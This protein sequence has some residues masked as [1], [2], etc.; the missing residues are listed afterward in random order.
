MDAAAAERA[1]EFWLG[2]WLQ[3]VLTGDYPKVMRE[4]L[5]E[6]LPRFSAE[7]AK[8]LAGSI[9]VLTLNHY[10]THLV[11]E[12]PPGEAGDTSN[13]WMADQRID[14]KWGDDW[15]QSASVLMAS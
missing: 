14:F 9:D 4:T 15:T 8:L 5:G 7:E 12:P 6:R 10:S 2:W 11:R 1:N 13:S 3:P